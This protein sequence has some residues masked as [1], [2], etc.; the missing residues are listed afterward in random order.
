MVDC[1]DDDVTVGDDVVVIGTQGTESIRAE[2]WAA[3]L[4]TI[5]YEVLCAISARVPRRHVTGSR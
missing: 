2:D 4:D 1:G 5:G 3:L